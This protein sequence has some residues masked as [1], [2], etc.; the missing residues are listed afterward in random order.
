MKAVTQGRKRFVGY[1]LRLTLGEFAAKIA[2]VVHLRDKPHAQ[3]G[4]VDRGGVLAF[5]DVG[6]PTVVGVVA[7][8]QEICNIVLISL[9]I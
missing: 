6:Q 7:V 5:D 9:M 2:G 1:T 3:N 4:R 8:H